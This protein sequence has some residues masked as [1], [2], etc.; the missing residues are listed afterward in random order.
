VDFFKIITE[1]YERKARL[2][3]ALLLIAPCILAGTM[4]FQKFQVAMKPLGTIFAAFGGI[5]LLVQLARDA[6][7]K[8]EAR[9]F[10]KWGGIPSV[11]IFRHQNTTLNE[12]TK[13]R[14]H[15]K[16]SRL[17]KTGKSPTVVQER[18]DPAS[19]DKIYS[20]W[21]IYLRL[22]TR[23]VKKY[24]LLFSENMNY[25]FRRNIWGLR[26]IGI[27]LMV[28]SFA[29]LAFELYQ[30]F[31]ITGLLNLR[32]AGAVGV[33]TI[34]ALLWIFRFTSDWVRLPADAY[35][36]RLAEAVETL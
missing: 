6:G 27:F 4:I 17:V 11:S 20:A 15:K 31:K 22:H 29:G 28:L 30:D 24:H 21:S 3:P 34:F 8:G 18:K 12:I 32:I 26:P 10:S 14:Y 23:D 35:A 19:A 5:Y 36:E 1:P 7:K 16:L 9:L 25:G 13:A 33:T 2:Y